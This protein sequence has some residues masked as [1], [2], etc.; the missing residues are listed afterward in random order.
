[1]DDFDNKSTNIFSEQEIPRSI[2]RVSLLSSTILATSN[3]ETALNWESGSCSLIGKRNS[4]EDRFV[5]ED[6]IASSSSSSNEK[7]SFYAVYDGHTGVEAAAYLQ[8]N[9]LKEICKH[10]QFSSDAVRAI[11]ETCCNIDKT[12]IEI[13]RE[14]RKDSGS[15]VLGIFLRGCELTLF[16]IGDSCA[17]L[18]TNGFAVRY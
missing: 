10:P 8:E 7:Q 3:N 5:M 15:T 9:L 14:R 4:N 2:P 13:C 12:F 6:N 18:S 11:E 1:M 16:N 17:V